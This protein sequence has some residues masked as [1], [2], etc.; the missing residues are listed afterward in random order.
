M[1]LRNRNFLAHETKKEYI[2]RIAQEDPFLKIEEIADLASTTRRYVR[3]ILSEANLSLMILREEYARKM[4]KEAKPEMVVFCKDSLLNLHLHAAPTVQHIVYGL[5]QDGMTEFFLNSSWRK[6]GEQFFCYIQHIYYGE[7]PIGLNMVIAPIQLN[8]QQ[9]SQRK[10]LLRL[11]EFAP[12]R[13]KLS[14]P[15]IETGKLADLFSGKLME[16]EFPSDLL[17]LKVSTLICEDAQILGEQIVY[18]P[19]EY[20]KLMISGNFSSL[21]EVLT[22]QNT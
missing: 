10:S 18:F 11:M 20:V 17:M 8:D 22:D 5:P 15:E 9:L 13:I 21:L 14:N 6:N 3:T 1:K 19:A 16:T 7:K 4:E 2:M 12:D